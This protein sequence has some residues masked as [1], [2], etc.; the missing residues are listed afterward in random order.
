MSYE[1]VRRYEVIVIS[2]EVLVRSWSGLGGV[3]L[4]LSG[5]LRL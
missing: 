5:I 3:R 4:W 1:V 2:Y